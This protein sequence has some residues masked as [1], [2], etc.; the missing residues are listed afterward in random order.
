MRWVLPA[1][2][3]RYCKNEVCLE[4]SWLLHRLILERPL[5][6]I[7]LSI[8]NF[9]SFPPDKGYILYKTISLSPGVSKHTLR[10]GPFVKTCDRI[11]LEPCSF[12]QLNERIPK[13]IQGMVSQNPNMSN[14]YIIESR[15]R[16][17]SQNR[18]IWSV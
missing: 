4:K 3:T 1:H 11:K 8:E 9:N 5:K 18:I 13:M 10:V 6:P 16:I 15:R 14:K 7:N 2:V 12:S 17:M